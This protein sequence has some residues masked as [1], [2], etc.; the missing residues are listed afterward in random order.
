MEITDY[1]GN[2]YI[3]ECNASPFIVYANKRNNQRIDNILNL[4]ELATK[5]RTALDNQTERY[6]AGDVE[7]A[8]V[9][10]AN[11]ILR[12]ERWHNIAWNK[13]DMPKEN[14]PVLVR[15]AVHVAEYCIGAYNKEKGWA[16]IPIYFGEI[17][18]WKYIM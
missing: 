13:E 3:A 11:E 2:K 9:T 8:Y 12:R 4:D 7:T 6:N 17:T 5:Y 15:S 1:V 14:T 16:G 10:G 18:D